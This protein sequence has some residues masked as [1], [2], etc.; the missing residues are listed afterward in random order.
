ME[1][2]VPIVR[3][4][5]QSGKTTAYKRALLN[6]V[7]NALATALEIPDDRIMQRIVETPGED[8]DTTEIRSDR[9]TIV[10]ISLIAGRGPELKE[11]L[12]TA[13]AK[14]LGFEPGISEHDLVVVLHEAVGECFFVNGAMPC[15][16]SGAGT[17]VRSSEEAGQ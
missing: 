12:Y 17:K 10:E 16:P 3:I 5:I 6:G 4:D 13:I 1:S 15:A 8:I 2:L 14:R 11:R 9:L 7:R